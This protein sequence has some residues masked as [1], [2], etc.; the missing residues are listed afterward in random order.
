[1]VAQSCV[2]GSPAA[3]RILPVEAFSG[4]RIPSYLMPSRHFHL[5]A[6]HALLT[7]NPSS[8]EEFVSN[9]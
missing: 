8:D 9:T 3:N 6:V 5:V 7:T 2:L 1:M 4:I